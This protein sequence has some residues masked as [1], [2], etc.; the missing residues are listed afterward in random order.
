MRFLSL[1]ATR[2]SHVPVPVHKI[3]RYLLST[4]SSY[5]FPYRPKRLASLRQRYCKY[6]HSQFQMVV[7]RPLCGIPFYDY[8]L[9]ESRLVYSI[10]RFKPLLWTNL[11]LSPFAG[12]DDWGIWIHHVPFGG[13]HTGIL[14]SSPMPVLHPVF[15]RTLLKPISRESS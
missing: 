8:N 1:T 15:V 7:Y 3:S 13:F 4:V 6:R 11:H 5:N 12:F 2:G 9:V 10:M 14:F